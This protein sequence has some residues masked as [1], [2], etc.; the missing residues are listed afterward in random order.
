MCALCEKETNE[1]LVC[2]FN[3][4]RKGSGSGYKSLAESLPKFEEIGQLPIKASLSSLNDG[5]EIE[6]TLKNAVHHG[7]KAVLIVALT[8][9]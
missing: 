9:S 8:K 7:T 2:P 5:S 6:Q 4:K 3:N 1:K